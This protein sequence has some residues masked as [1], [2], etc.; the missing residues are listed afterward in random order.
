M[1][2][3]TASH[4]CEAQPAKV[5]AATLRSP[6]AGAHTDDVPVLVARDGEQEHVHPADSMDVDPI[7]VGD[8][9]GITVNGETTV[10]EESD[11]A[12]TKAEAL[13]DRGDSV[14]GPQWGEG[15]TTWHPQ[16][17]I[18]PPSDHNNRAALSAIKSEG[19]KQEVRRLFGPD[20]WLKRLNDGVASDDEG[21]RHECDVRLR[22][23][24]FCEQLDFQAHESEVVRVYN[25]LPAEPFQP[26]GGHEP[27]EC[28]AAR[29]INWVISD[30]HP[31]ENGE[32]NVATSSEYSWDLEYTPVKHDPTT[33]PYCHQCRC[34]NYHLGEPPKNGVETR[35]L[36]AMLLVDEKR[37]Q[38]A[39][40]P[41][42]A[43]NSRLQERDGYNEFVTRHALK[44]IQAFQ[45]ARKHYDTDDE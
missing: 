1:S 11:G 17:V 42:A 15:R 35:I 23:T 2:T 34:G 30:V 40:D 25:G 19:H 28:Q 37:I 7:H 18:V 33:C 3:D 39:D 5:V 26:I 14:L 36:A 10:A 13:K 24:T 29:C 22:I 8:P 32:M 16:D 12:L 43:F 31:P 38:A 27:A 4:D 9:V 20:S 6:Y 41:Q 21:N 45:A 44:P